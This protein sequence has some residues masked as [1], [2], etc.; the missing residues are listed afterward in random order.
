[1]WHPAI[2]AAYRYRQQ[3]YPNAD[4]LVGVAREALKPVR[5]VHE[6][7]AARYADRYSGGAL[8]IKALLDE[9][10]PLLYT[11]EELES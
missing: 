4:G 8:L 7:W 5:G 2:E 3:Q 9:L 11:S 10:A 1:M 6:R